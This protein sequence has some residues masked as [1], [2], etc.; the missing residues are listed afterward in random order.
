MAKVIY[1]VALNGKQDINTY[2]VLLETPRTYTI[3]RPIGSVV[4]KA[5]MSDRWENFFEDRKEAEEFLAS[6]LC[7][8][9]QAT[10]CIDV[11]YIHKELTD[12]YLTNN[13]SD[14]L[15]SLIMYIEEFV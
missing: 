9:K 13:C 2:E 7:T 12:I 5:A 15:S 6:L 3:S 11:K 10:R 14:K 4:R 1:G 8:I